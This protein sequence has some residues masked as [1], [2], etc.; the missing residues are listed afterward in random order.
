MIPAE[1][2]TQLQTSV[3]DLVQRMKLLQDTNWLIYKELNLARERNE[4]LEKEK[5]DAIDAGK[6]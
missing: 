4:R 3:F 6:V 1:V 5:A 2:I